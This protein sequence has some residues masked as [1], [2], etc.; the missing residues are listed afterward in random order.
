MKQSK[1]VV[2]LL[3]TYNGADY[4][5]EQLDSLINQ[6]YKNIEIIVRDDGSKDG[7]P[8]I[9]RE[10]ENKNLIRVM[11]GE[12][13]GL[14][15]SIFTLIK[16]AGEA[17]YYSLAEQDDVWLPQKL[18][19]AVEHLE[20]E[21]NDLIQ[22]YTSG[23]DYYDSN[24]KFI[25]KGPRLAYPRSLVRTLVVT[26]I[27]LGFTMVLNATT[28][29]FIDESKVV[30][31][32]LSCYH[33]YWLTLMGLSLGNI[34]Y[35]SAVTTKYRRH[36]SNISTFKTSFWAIQKDRFQKFIFGDELKGYFT[37][38]H[39]FYE[40]YKDK[41]SA[42]NR[43]YFELFDNRKYSIGKAIKKCFL[44][45]RYRDSWFDEIGLRL[46]FIFGKM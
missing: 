33:D 11:Y 21:D 12:N 41:M 37:A 22:I 19:R 27:Y 10:Y 46:L 23:Y 40:L 45:E 8:E 15:K 29:R 35:D 30:D 1:K 34:V 18:E 28:K 32:K 26:H 39:D 44:R 42:K 36:E 38:N 6:S 20:K 3:S 7:T 31:M 43:R 4:L 24:M 17:D 2:V 13:V 9:L 5:K 16:E 14:N 25:G